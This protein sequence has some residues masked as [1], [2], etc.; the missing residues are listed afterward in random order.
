MSTTFIPLVVE[1]A[2]RFHQAWSAPPS[3]ASDTLRCL[4]VDASAVSVADA[5]EQ[6]ADPL[7]HRAVLHGHVEHVGRQSRRLSS[8]A[9]RAR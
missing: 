8:A 5:H 9:C 3:T 4:A 6:L 7:E 1:P 2:H